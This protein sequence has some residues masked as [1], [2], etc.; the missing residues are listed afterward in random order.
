M[1]ENEYNYEESAE[2]NCQ[3]CG[4]TKIFIILDF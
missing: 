3:N 2:L 1:N 4:F